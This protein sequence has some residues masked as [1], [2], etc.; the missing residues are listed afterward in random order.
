MRSSFQT[1]ASQAGT[2]QSHHDVVEEMFGQDDQSED[3]PL[4]Q[5]G[6]RS[7]PAQEGVD[8]RILA[9]SATLSAPRCSSGA[10]ISVVHPSGLEY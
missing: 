3:D 4:V 8:W 5:D 10:D 9:A 6:W 1:S 7:L 2:S